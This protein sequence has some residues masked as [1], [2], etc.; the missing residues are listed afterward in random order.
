MAV[1][2][3]ELMERMPGAFLPEKA[4]DT[5]AVIQFEFTGAEPGSWHAAIHNGTCEVNE[6]QHANPTMTLMADSSDYID[7]ITGK[8]DAMKAFM[9]GKVKLTG[10][11]NLAMKMTSFFK[12][13][14]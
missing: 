9:Q 7:I 13:G 2:I 12:L 14:G 5:E 6:G 8:T 4:G 10:N 1:T 11:L 3:K